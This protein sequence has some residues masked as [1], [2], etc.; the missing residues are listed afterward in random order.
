M[1]IIDILYIIGNL[2]MYMLLGAIILITI[3][4]LYIVIHRELPYIK[5]YIKKI[6]K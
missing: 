6:F 4:A 5:E 3:T 2:I 1:I